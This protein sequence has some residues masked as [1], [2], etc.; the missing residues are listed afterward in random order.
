MTVNDIIKCKKLESELNVLIEKYYNEYLKNPYE[1][2]VRWEWADEQNTICIVYT[3][4]NYWD[5]WD[6]DYYHVTFEELV[7]F[8]PENH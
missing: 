4:L 7:N 2:Y 5:E 3:Y 6:T 1:E 8:K